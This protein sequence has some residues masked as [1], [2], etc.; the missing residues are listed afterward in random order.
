V[1]VQVLMEYA[2]E[3]VRPAVDLKQHALRVEYPAVPIWLEVDPVRITQVITNLLANAAKYTP[4]NGEI[5]LQTRMEPQHFVISVRDNGVGLAP[6]A[7]STVF[8]MFTR[9]DTEAT[10]AEGGLGI[11]LALAKGLTLLHGGQLQVHSAGRGQGSE[12]TIC[13]PRSVVVAA[14]PVEKPSADPGEKRAPLRILIADDNRDAAESL[15]M[16]LKLSGHEIE[17]AHSGGAAFAVAG[18]FRPQIG[19]IDIGMPDMNGYEVVRRIRHEAWGEKMTLIAV[20]GWGQADDKRRALAAGFDQHMTK[21]VD[22][23]ELEAAFTK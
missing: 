10:R 2:V 22:P 20:T 18:T 9:I 4:A 19:I 12:F 16:L 11:G 23:E 3:A 15:G 1:N 21:P 6:S 8:Q 5:S 7:V 13:L 14:P 17:I